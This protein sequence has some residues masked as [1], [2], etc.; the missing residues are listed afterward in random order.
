MSRSWHRSHSCRTWALS[1][2]LL[3]PQWRMY[4]NSVVLSVYRCSTVLRMSSVK[5]RFHRCDG[6]FR[7]D[8]ERIAFLLREVTE[9]RWTLRIG[10]YPPNLGRMHPYILFGNLVGDVKFFLSMLRYPVKMS[11]FV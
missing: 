4:H 3:P 7:I 2:R 6:F 10:H 9:H 11:E 5:N 8:M 1:M